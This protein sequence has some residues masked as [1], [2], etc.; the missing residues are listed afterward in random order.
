MYIKMTESFTEYNDSVFV[1][2]MQTRLLLMSSVTNTHWVITIVMHG[3]VIQL[4]LVYYFMQAVL[5]VICF[6]VP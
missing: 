6:S 1:I 5:L 2:C 3:V 4:N